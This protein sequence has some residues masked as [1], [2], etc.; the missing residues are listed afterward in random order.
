LALFFVLVSV[1][2]A[3]QLVASLMEMTVHLQGGLGINPRQTPHLF[4]T[5]VAL[6]AVGAVTGLSAAV[7]MAMQ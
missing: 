5:L 1:V 7:V 2:F 6:Q 4:W 3:V